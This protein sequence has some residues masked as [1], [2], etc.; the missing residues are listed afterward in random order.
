MPLDVQDLLLCW[1][2]FQDQDK[3]NNHILGAQSVPLSDIVGSTWP[4]STAYVV[5]ERP[6]R[7]LAGNVI[8]CAAV[9]QLCFV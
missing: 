4:E 7:E 6:T 9:H 8:D 1:P 2:D 5:K 3:R